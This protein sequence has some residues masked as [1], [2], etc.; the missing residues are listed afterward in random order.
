VVAA[1]DSL[2]RLSQR[3]YGN[4]NRWQE[5]YNANAALLGPNGVLKVGT[6]LRI[7]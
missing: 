3:Y 4:A 5:I 6:Q 2:S 7:P 1:G